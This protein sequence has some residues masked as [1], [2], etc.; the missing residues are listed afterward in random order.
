MFTNLANSHCQAWE[1]LTWMLVRPGSWMYW[2]NILHLTDDSTVKL[3]WHPKTIL[4]QI[5]IRYEFCHISE[6]PLR[7]I[8]DF[9][10][11]KKKIT[12]AEVELDPGIWERLDTEAAEEGFWMTESR[13]RSKASSTCPKHL[14][15]EI[16][17]H[18]GVNF[19]H[20][21]V[22]KAF[23]HAKR[24]VSLNVFQLKKMR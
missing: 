22:N 6:G 13:P 14:T 10:C 3:F 1:P 20:N 23:V 5:R 8:E 16:F 9:L 21:N 18:V 4:G 17:L 24:K 12:K 7:S 11:V 2:E 19:P 15:P